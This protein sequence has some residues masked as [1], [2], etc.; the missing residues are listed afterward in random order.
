MLSF[1]HV[2]HAGVRAGCMPII[3]TGPQ[4]SMI[5]PVT[6]YRGVVQIIVDRGTCSTDYRG[7]V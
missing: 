5:L 1:T 3:V 7:Y 2:V 6:G 4:G